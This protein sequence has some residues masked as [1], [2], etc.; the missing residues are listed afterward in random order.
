M[1]NL[2]IL[3]FLIPG[4]IFAKFAK[5]QTV[6][7]VINKYIDALGGKEKLM[8]LKSVRLDGVMNVQGTDINITTT[9][10]HMKGMRV[11]IVVAG[12]ENYQ[13][14]TPEKGIIFMPIQG[15]TSPTDMKEDQ[16]KSGQI[17]L[18]VQSPLFNYKEKGTVVELL[19]SEILDGADNYKL[20]LTFKNAGT[21]TYFIGKDNLRLNKSVSKRNINGEEMELATT[22][23]NYKQNEDGYWFAYASSGV[24]GE[25]YYDKIE[26]NIAVDE[27]IF[28]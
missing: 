12:T 3:G 18:D 11:D 4:L 25:M 14:V 2:I 24:Q 26:T 6:D 16:L 17:Q 8:S 20:K 5:A 23:S 22:Y 13:I 21:T 9:K 15:I 19:G 28:K 7:E 1:K 10:L 27:N